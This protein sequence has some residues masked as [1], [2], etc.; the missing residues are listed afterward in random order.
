MQSKQ[1]T[2]MVSLAAPEDA[3][4]LV[5]WERHLLPL[6]QAGHLLLWSERLILGGENRLQQMSQQIDQ[7][8]LIVFLLSAD[9]FASDECTHLMECALT[10]QHNEQVTLVPLLLRPSAWQDSP[11]STLSCLPHQERAVTSWD[12]ADEAFQVCV[13]DMRQLLGLPLVE[14]ARKS[15]PSVP[16]TLRLQIIHVLQLE[17]RRRRDHSLQDQVAI[18]LDL[19]ERA[20]VISSSA[21]LVFHD[22][23]AKQAL[24]AGTTIVQVYDRTQ[25]GL[26]ILGAPGSGK[27][28]LLLDLT[29]ELL[30]RAENNEEHP[31]PIILSLSS[32]GTTRLAF[33]DWLCEQLY[34]VY[35]IARKVGASWIEQDQILLLLDGLDEMAPSARAACVTAINSYRSEHLAPVVVTSRSREYEQQQGRL[36]LPAAVEIQPLEFTRVST[37]LKQAGPSL[38]AVHTAFENYVQGSWPCDVFCTFRPR[39]SNRLRL[40]KGIQFLSPLN[41]PST[42]YHSTF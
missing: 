6:Q 22:A 23:E 30:R 39:R 37:Y 5:R 31:L 21:S 41:F 29:L 1:S 14:R 42:E 9:F 2:L 8:N 35:G 38:A 40:E 19:H 3:A 32:W 7:A 16:P 12:N 26:L 28:T 18:E 25:F 10:R 24:P 36:I 11:L 4:W 27:T 15:Q 17:Y 34:L 20:D 13:G 33:V